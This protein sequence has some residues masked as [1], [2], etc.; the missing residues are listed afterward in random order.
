[1]RHE[2]VSEE[3]K[4][5]DKG[6]VE[7]QFVCAQDLIQPNPVF[8]RTQSTI[9]QAME[10]F[11][12]Q[13]MN[14]LLVVSDN[15]LDDSLSLSGR[16]CLKDVFGQIFLCL[17]QKDLINLNHVLHKSIEKIIVHSQK[18]VNP[19]SNITEILSVMLADFPFVTGVVHNGILVGQI[20]CSDLLRLFKPISGKIS[21]VIE[22]IRQALPESAK[23]HKAMARHILCLSPKDEISKVM[24]VLMASEASSIPVL[25]DQG[26][27]RRI[28]SRL[29]VLE[30]I[31][32]LLESRELTVF[33][34]KGLILDRTIGSLADKEFV[35][36]SN[37]NCL[38]EAVTKMIENNVFCLAVTDI[39]RRFCGLLAFT[40]ILN[41]VHAHLQEQL[42]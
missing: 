15:P 35:T 13:G 31:L 9:Q 22:L 5:Y 19:R 41:W 1:M 20:C 21:P 34:Q 12:K 32:Q 39:Q 38:S 8:L 42:H 6:I 24:G 16:V 36:I 25:D 11:R 7:G 3:K 23:I 27:L 26:N 30:Y 10:A 14:S 2:T 29:D 40:D 4:E 28:I 17:V 33:E 37:E 18:T